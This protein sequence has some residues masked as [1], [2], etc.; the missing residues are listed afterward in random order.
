MVL[1]LAALATVVPA[2]PADTVGV[3]IVVPR[4]G[5]FFG[6]ACPTATTCEAVGDSG[7]GEVLVPI[8]DGIPGAPIP[9]PGTYE[10]HGIACETAT[11]CIA[12]GDNAANTGVVVPITNTTPGV[13]ITIPGTFSVD[14]IACPSATSCTAV[15]AASGSLEGVVVPIAGTTPGAPVPAPGTRLSAIA[16]ET[17]TSC[18]AVGDDVTSGVVLPITNGMPGTA[19][20]VPGGPR[21]MYAIACQTATTC[22]AV[23]IDDNNFGD[24]ARIS[25]GVPA[26]AVKPPRYAAFFGIACESDTFCEGV[27]QTGFTQKGAVVPIDSGAPGLPIAA[28]G[29]FARPSLNAIACV[30]ASRCEVV[31]TSGYNG[32]VVATC[33]P[34]AVQSCAAVSGQ[35]RTHRESVADDV[36][37]VGLS[38]QSCT[39]TAQLTTP[40]SGQ[41][42]ATTTITITP[43][44]TDAVKLKLNRTGKRLLRK[45]RNLPVTLT[46]S[47]SQDAGPF[48][49]LERSLVLRR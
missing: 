30:S 25:N 4:A 15:G 19:V 26:S 43:G 10:L 32:L 24:V 17:T 34:A 5:V 2:A 41:P 42:V 38:G 29:D 49:L 6:V 20:T 1:A 48:V 46:I 47:Q 23:G 16:C 9:V 7:S 39:I 22:T 3:P 13:P 35:A 11:S 12:V 37:C 21:T 8:R 14:G 28:P 18:T 40:A 27:G 44:Q 31:G 45:H 36:A 33:I